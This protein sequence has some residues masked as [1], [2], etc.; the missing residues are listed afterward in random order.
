MGLLTVFCLLCITKCLG[1][2]YMKRIS[3][4]AISS[5]LC[6]FVFTCLFGEN[7]TGAVRGD[8]SQSSDITACLVADENSVVE[9]Y[10]RSALS[11]LENSEALLF[12][13]DSITAGAEKCE[14][15][16]SVYDGVHSITYDEIKTVVDAYVRDRADHFW[17]GP[18]YSVTTNDQTVLRVKPTYLMEGDELS[19]ARAEFERCA[20]ELLR[21]TEGAE[22]EFER[23]L[24]LHDA[25]AAKITYT[26]ET[27]NAYNSYG[28]IVEGAG[29]CEAYSEAL[30][31][32]LLRSGIQ[33]FLITGS[34]VNPSA[35]TAVGHEWNMV[36]IDGKYYY[37]D[38]TWDDQGENIFH[39]YFNQPEAVFLLDHDITPTAYPLPTCDSEDAS[40]FSVRGGRIKEYKADEIG[41]LMKKNFFR[42]QVF[43]DGNVDDFLAWYYDNIKD[44]ATAAGVTGGFNYGYLRL[45]KELI[46]V[47]N[48]LAAFCGVS[49]AVD[50]DISLKYY[51]QAND[52]QIE[53]LGEL[54]VAFYVSDH[55]ILADRYELIDGYYVFT[56]DGIPFHKMTEKIDAKLILMTGNDA[57]I[58]GEKNGYS[59]EKYCHE[60]VSHF[61]NDV[62]LVNLVSDMLVF[63]KAAQEYTFST[64]PPVSVDGSLFT[65]T[66]AFPEVDDAFV[67]QGNKKSECYVKNIS[68]IFDGRLKICI[69]V[70]CEDFKFDLSVDGMNAFEIYLNPIGGGVFRY[71]LE[72]TEA[73][74]IDTVHT[75]ELK[76]ELKTV[77][78]LCWSINSYAL[79]L[80]DYSADEKL[81]SLI[82]AAYRFGKSADTYAYLNG[83]GI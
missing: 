69:D 4:I 29:V 73:L 6:F 9:Y 57:R 41:L 22:S 66:D 16:I 34:S 45:G 13:Y 21:L 82:T 8:A 32:L 68:V 15:S 51:V 17:V 54:A 49:L 2:N 52:D 46:L 75:F 1:E 53:T 12:A 44:I 43:I 81:T 65:P 48:P 42:P 28:A 58:L 59:V 33:S 80:L 24:I 71:V 72:P 14:K 5:I 55:L 78:Y 30:Q 60:L 67:M 10:G 31:C 62:P 26:K 38:L 27:K 77:S 19:K 40:Y 23:E 64:M 61:K 63:G 56:V 83:M 25:L 50:T 76:Y 47:L 20:N 74:G 18:S 79:E 37:T 70:Y 35:G 36:R 3:G 11:A 7:P 39:A